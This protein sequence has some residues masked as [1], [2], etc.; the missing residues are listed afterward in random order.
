MNI[1]YNLLGI[2]WWGERRELDGGCVVENRCVGRHVD[3]DPSFYS[4]NKL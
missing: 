1:K 2:P 4:V 3:I